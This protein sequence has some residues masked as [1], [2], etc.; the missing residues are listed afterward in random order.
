MALL[1]VALM[2]VLDGVPASSPVWIAAAGLGPF[3]LGMTRAEALRAAPCRLRR[4][5]GRDAVSDLSCGNFRLLKSKM[6]LRLSFRDDR[7]SSI[8]LSRTG[9]SELQARQEIDVVL[10]A[11]ASEFGMLDSPQLPAQ[12]VTPEAAFGNLKRNLTDASTASLS[13]KPVTEVDGFI[14]RAMFKLSRGAVPR[15]DI[16]DS[17]YEGAHASFSGSPFDLVT[18]T[19]SVTIRSF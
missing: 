2:F 19:V 3:H 13:V 1:A 17:W 9:Y 4:P 14:V 16:S 7:L 10:R 6:E 11:L 8:G 12:A 18:H 5:A 15:S